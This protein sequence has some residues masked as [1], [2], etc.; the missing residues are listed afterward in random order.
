[1]STAS[2]VTG[3]VG[4]IA[5][6]KGQRL[7]NLGSLVL[8][9]NKQFVDFDVNP[10]VDENGIPLTPIRHLLEKAGGEVNW[11]AFQKAIEAKAGG[12]EI[13]IQIGDK[14]A[15]IDGK[16]VSMEVAPFIENGRAI[17]PLSFIR[18]TLNVDIEYDKAT[19][20]VLITPI[21]K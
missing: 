7:P 8:V 3:A 1:V 18:E 4:K 6:T 17:V 13:F 12:R 21:K 14:D 20:H 16:T 2:N 15:K 9:Y 11:K 19:G 5:I 10:R